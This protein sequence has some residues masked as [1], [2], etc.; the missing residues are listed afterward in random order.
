VIFFCACEFPCF[1]GKLSCHRD[2]V[3][4]LLL[5]EARKKERSISVVEWP[6]G[7]PKARRLEVECKL[8]SSVL[9][10][11]WYIPFEGRRLAEFAEFAG[12]PWG[13]I[14]TLGCAQPTANAFVAVG[15]ARFPA[16]TSGGTHW[17]LPVFW[18][19]EEGKAKASVLR[20]TANWRR[21]CG[22]NERVCHLESD[23]K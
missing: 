19:A 10:G 4:G 17:R 22:L 6:G 9:N 2:T 13:S 11:R 14:L 7:K 12:L 20:D 3:T 1:E 23:R 16:P 8:F 5:A 18:Q 21:Q 15:P